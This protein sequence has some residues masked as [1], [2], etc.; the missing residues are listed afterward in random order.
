VV[1]RPTTLVDVTGRC[2]LGADRPV[3]HALLVQLV[4][5]GNRLG[6]LLGVRL[7]AL[8]LAVTLADALASQP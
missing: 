5:E 8:A 4:G 3:T 1:K 7:P 2:Q 6:A